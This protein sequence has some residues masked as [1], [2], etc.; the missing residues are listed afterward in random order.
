MWKRLFVSLLAGLV[1]GTAITAGLYRYQQES[2]TTLPPDGIY[3]VMSIVINEPDGVLDD[4]GYTTVATIDDGRSL[5]INLH[6]PQIYLESEGPSKLI[7]ES[8]QPRF[9]VR[10]GYTR[11]TISAETRVRNELLVLALTISVIWLVAFLVLAL[12]LPW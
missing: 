3:P 7:I 8:G 11:T 12:L 4:I 1:L 2:R 9:S 5:E 10:S 6:G